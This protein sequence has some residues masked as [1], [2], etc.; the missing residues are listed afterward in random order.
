[1]VSFG[2]CNQLKSM[3][4]PIHNTSILLISHPL[5]IHC[6]YIIDLRK[7]RVEQLQNEAARTTTQKPE[8]GEGI[9]ERNQLNYVIEYCTIYIHGLLIGEYGTIFIDF[10]K[11]N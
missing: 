11:I 7:Q 3:Y 10:V 9:Y 1:M 4:L 6:R 2:F 5:K 8:R